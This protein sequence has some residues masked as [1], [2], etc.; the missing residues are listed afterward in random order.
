MENSIYFLE[1]IQR[2]E[3]EL[4]T[5]LEVKVGEDLSIVD[6]LNRAKL[7][8]K[9]RQ[10]TIADL[11]ILRRVRNILSHNHKGKEFIN[12]PISTIKML[13]EI[14]SELTNPPLVTHFASRGVVTCEIDDNIKDI[15][16]LMVKNDYSQ[17]PV[18]SNGTFKGL[19]T[20]N[21][22]ARWLGHRFNIDGIVDEENSIEQVLP[23]SESSKNY[24]FI[25]RVSRLSDVI[26]FFSNEAT[27]NN[28][29]DALLITENGK[30]TQKILGIITKSDLPKIVLDM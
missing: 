20:T 8:S 22:I 25:S 12:I 3:N 13:E 21:T 1:L 15:L 17:I 19:L 5:I 4:K 9:I 24:A 10:S 16:A 11:D 2:I 23:H 28:F 6:M 26:D 18:L 7:S 14:L 30:E 29:F 27:T